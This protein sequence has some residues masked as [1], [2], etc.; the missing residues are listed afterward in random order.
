MGPRACPP[1]KFQT[2]HGSCRLDSALASVELK[3]QNAV[4]G[5]WQVESMHSRRT[6]DLF[7]ISSSIRL[8]LSMWA[9]RQSSSSRVGVQRHA[10]S[11]HSLRPCSVYIG[12]LAHSLLWS[13]SNHFGRHRLITQHSIQSQ[14]HTLLLYITYHTCHP[15][16]FHFGCNLL[17]GQRFTPQYL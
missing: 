4:T 10:V 2:Q 8:V 16:L 1:T 12:A 11:M 13:S 9:M 6:E 3:G 7:L 17:P 14:Q 15:N 5:S